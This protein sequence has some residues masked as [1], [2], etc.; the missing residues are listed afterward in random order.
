MHTKTH[1]STTYAYALLFAAAA[2]VA[3]GLSFGPVTHAQSAL[4]CSPSTTVVGVGQPVTFSASGGDG[5]YI[6]TGPN[7][8]IT[9][10]NGVQFVVTYPSAGLYPITVTS[11]GDTATCTM[12]VTG[13]TTSPA[14]TY[15]GLPNTGGGY[16]N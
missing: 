5:T 16:G 13:G 12:N 14:P 6:W 9:N 15:P 11:D 3:V 4:T 1:L 2:L 10:P 8:N 7:L